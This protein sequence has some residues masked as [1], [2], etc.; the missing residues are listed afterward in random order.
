MEVLFTGTAAAG[1]IVAGMLA[2]GL[3]GI[4]IMFIRKDKK[5]NG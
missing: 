3:V 1:W 5:R 4:K 2:A